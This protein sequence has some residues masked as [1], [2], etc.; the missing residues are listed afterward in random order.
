[1]NGPG[2]LREWGSWRDLP[3]DRRAELLSRAS[4]ALIYDERLRRDIGTIVDDV[5]TNGDDALIRITGQY[6]GVSLDSSTIRVSDE[7]LETAHSAISADLRDAI[8]EAISHIGTFN[9]EIMARTSWQT[10]TEFGLRIGEKVTPIASAGLFVPSGK[11]SYPSVM[12]QLGVPAVL[13]GVSRIAVVV[14]PGPSGRVDPAV[15]AVA[16]ELGIRSVFRVNG[17]AGVAALAFGTETIPS[18]RKV[19]GPGSPAVMCAQLLIQTYGCASINL[20]GPSE[21]MILADRSAN[22]RLLAADLLNE[23]EHGPD[24]ASLLVTDS[25]ELAE[26]VQ[27]ELAALLESLPEPRRRY[28]RLSL[29]VNGGTVLARDIS[30]GVAV[31]NAYAPEHLE[32][33]VENAP[34]AIANI[35]NAGEILVGPWTPISS[36]NFVLGCPAVLPTC[37]FADVSS[38]VT[39]NAFLKR[40]AVVEA[41]RDAFL[42]VSKAAIILAEHEG[43]PAHEAAI[44]AR[45]TSESAG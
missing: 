33:V 41:D 35:Y 27:R 30:E 43:F 3:P 5:R 6:D 38:G 16:S 23:A 45:L 13:A 11:A 1:V 2:P 8:R 14:P 44:R 22:V 19:V 18:V 26:E 39:V 20:F 21:S 36:A 7:E 40:S 28:A 10:E 9:R 24:S 12:M 25:P 37:G 17:P 34:Q 31:V 15:L 42:R 32:V 29:G 4:N